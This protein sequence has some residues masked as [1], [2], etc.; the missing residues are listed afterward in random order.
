MTLAAALGIARRVWW[1]FP[2][3]ALLAALLVTRGTL[4]G[5]KAELRAERA[6]H[7]TTVANYRAAAE[8]RKASD[9]A[10]VARVRTNRPNS[11]RKSPMTIRPALPL[12]ALIL[13]SACGARPQ[14]IP[15]APGPRICPAFPMPPEELMRAP[16]K[17]DF[18]RG[19]P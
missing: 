16:V 1:A 17:R 10:N 6:A 3:A 9:I 14:P 18:L 4:A 15:A 11:R 12:C 13:L 19:T 7:E 8:R 2:V 5:A